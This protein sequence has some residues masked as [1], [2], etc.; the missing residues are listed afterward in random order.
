MFSSQS[1]AAVTATT[2]LSLFHKLMRQRIDKRKEESEQEP[3]QKPG[4]KINI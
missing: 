2:D 3:Q 4:L 1:T